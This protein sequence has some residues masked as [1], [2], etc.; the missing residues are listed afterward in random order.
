MRFSLLLS[1]KY[2]I[3]WIVLA[4]QLMVAIDFPIAWE[5]YNGSLWLLSP[6]C[7]CELSLK[8]ELI[9]H[10][11]YTYIFV[12]GNLSYRTWFG[13]GMIRNSGWPVMYMLRPVQVHSL[14]KVGEMSCKSHCRGQLSSLSRQL[15]SITASLKGNHRALITLKVWQSSPTAD[16]E[17]F[18]GAAGRPVDHSCQRTDH[19]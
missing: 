9:V 10:N 14:Q 15:G 7:K 17:K 13:Q 4:K 1:T 6:A 5:K 12:T 3:F 18:L 19:L 16:W 8:I 2:D 11:I